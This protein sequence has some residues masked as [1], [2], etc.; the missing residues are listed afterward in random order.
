MAADRIRSSSPSIFSGVDYLIDS[1]LQLTGDVALGRAAIGNPPHHEHDSS[2]QRLS[3]LPLKGFDSIALLT[4]IYDK[5][6]T[7]WDTSSYH[8]GSDEN[9]RLDDPRTELAEGNDSPE[10]CLERAIVRTMNA[11]EPNSMSWVN[12]V[13]VASG[14]V[15]AT[16]D[17]SRKIDLVHKLDEKTFELIELKVRSDTPLYAAMEILKSAVVYAFCRHDSRVQQSIFKDRKLLEAERIHLRVL[18]PAAYYKNYDLAWLETGL[19]EGLAEF[20]IAQGLTFASDFAFETLAFIER[21]PT[22]WPS[23]P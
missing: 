15:H 23:E 2:C 9:W 14:L 21:S 5:I 22:K 1:A 6:G 8:N 3:A 18:A 19:N 13:P 12:Q 17:R 20:R 7:N 4:A 16:A 11:L 10:V